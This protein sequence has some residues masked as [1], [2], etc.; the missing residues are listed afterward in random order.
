MNSPTIHAEHL[1]KAF[2][3]KHVLRDLSFNVMPGDV[4]GVLGKNGAGKTT[5][6]ELMLGFTPPTTGE[7]SVFGHPSRQMPGAVKKRV[8]FVPQ[9]DELLDP[10]LVRDQ[11]SLIAAFYPQWNQEL[12]ADLCVAWN[13]N[14]GARI[15]TMSVGER[16]KLSILLAFGQRPELL[17]LDEPVA[18]LD[19]LARR[20][21]LE[22]LV[23]LSADE[24]RA[25]VFS[26]HIVSDIERLANRI[27][28]LKEGQLNW[29]GELDALKES[30]AR[31]HVQGSG[32]LPERIDIPG[33][34]SWRRLDSGAVAIVRDWTDQSQQALQQ[35]LNCVIRVEALGLEEIFLE[36]HR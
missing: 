15:K 11:I 9:Q 2:G 10:L 33:L 32:A 30:I 7:I 13:I 1:S 35:Q 17:I 25:V 31:L 20:Q 22:Q 28:I 27:W 21:F 4:I 36:L 14:T 5:L 8:G 23:E 29:Q 24:R 3:D 19:P 16:Q 12:V 34:L 18:S 6:L 26:S